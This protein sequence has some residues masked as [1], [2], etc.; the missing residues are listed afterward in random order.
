MIS[1]FQMNDQ[2]LLFMAT[3]NKS[4]LNDFVSGI[5]L[6]TFHTFSIFLASFSNSMHPLHQIIFTLL[7][8]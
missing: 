7:N 4:W 5:M 2:G 6:D 8:L 1:F 3:S